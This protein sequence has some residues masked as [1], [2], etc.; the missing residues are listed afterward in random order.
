MPWCETN[1]VAVVGYSPFGSGSFP[2]RDAPGGRVLAEVAAAHDATPRRA[3]LA[4][5]ARRAFVIPK[6][7]RPQHAAENAGAGDLQLTD[8]E[9]A[10]IDAAFPRGRKPRSLP[11]I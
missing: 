9:I 11:M 1:H 10:R 6:A 7:S 2:G 8:G 3:A 5:L 4:F